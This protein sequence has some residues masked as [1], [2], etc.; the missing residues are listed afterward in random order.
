M[1]GW[2]IRKVKEFNEAGQRLEA[3][4]AEEKKTLDEVHQAVQSG[5]LSG[6]QLNDISLCCESI[7]INMKKRGVK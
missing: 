5:K 3:L 6:D 7:T 1:I 2:I 4:K